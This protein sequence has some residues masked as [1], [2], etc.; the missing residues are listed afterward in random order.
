M[1]VRMEKDLEGRAWWCGVRRRGGREG[2]GERRGGGA[3]TR[4]T[5]KRVL[6]ASTISGASPMRAAVLMALERPG[7]PHS[8]RKVGCSFSS[9]NSTLAFSKRGSSYFRLVR[10]LH[11]SRADLASGFGARSCQGQDCDGAPTAGRAWEVIFWG[12][13]IGMGLD[14]RGVSAQGCVGLQKL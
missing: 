13:A 5:P 2:G 10:A 12:S 14:T 6:A 1:F 4:L 9:S 11:S 3:L 8:R 7:M